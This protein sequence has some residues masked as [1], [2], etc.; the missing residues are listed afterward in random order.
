MDQTKTGK[1]IASKRKEH[2]LTQS[3]LAE[4]LVLPIRSCQNGK[5][6]FPKQ[7]N[8]RTTP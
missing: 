4:K 3:Q 7:K 5:P 6:E 1:F 2:S 8:I